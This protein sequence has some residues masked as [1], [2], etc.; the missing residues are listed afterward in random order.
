MEILILKILSILALILS[1]I[2]THAEIIKLLELPLDNGLNYTYSVDQIKPCSFIGVNKIITSELRLGKKSNGIIEQINLIQRKLNLEL[3]STEFHADRILISLKSAKN[4]VIEFEV[5]K[6]DCSII[7]KAHINNKVSLLDEIEIEYG[8]T[9][10]SPVIKKLTLV[11]EG[12]Y[13]NLFLYPWALQGQISTYELSAGL[14]LNFHSNIRVN[15]LNSFE[16]NNPAIVPIPAFFFRYT[17]IFLNKNGLGSLIYHADDFSLL[18]MGLLEGEPYQASGLLE[19]KKGF[20]LGSLLKFN[21]LEF[22]YYN[23]FFTKKGYNLKLNLSPEFYVRM[24]WKITPQLYLQYWDKKYVNYYFGVQAGETASGMKAYQS[25]HTYNYGA[26]FEVMHFVANWT[27]IVDLGVKN[28]G[29]E[30]YSSPTVNKK[31]EFQLITSVL[32]KFF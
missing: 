12:N 14:A 26:M 17:T 1:P 16:R 2:I 25:G 30:V 22:I 29:P 31:S 24:D 27:Y 18:A 3:E 7:K 15:N 21:F 6:K 8:R 20:F 32:Y 5:N 9:L 13:L 19:R 4:L 10:Y 23:D 11:G 28:Y